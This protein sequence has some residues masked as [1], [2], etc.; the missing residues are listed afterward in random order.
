MPDLIA[1]DV[2]FSISDA[3]AAAQRCDTALRAR[4]PNSVVLTYGHLGDGNL[5]LI[6][7]VPDGEP[8]CAAAVET[9]IYRI[10]REYHGSVSAEH[11]IGAKKMGVLGYSRTPQEIAVMRS[12]KSALDPRNI[13]NPGKLLPIDPL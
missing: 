10:V 13:L 5:H 4:W 7:Q 6:V 9:E 3:G 1:F 11:G 12:I 8:Y 2:G